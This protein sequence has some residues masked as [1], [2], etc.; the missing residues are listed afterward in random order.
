MVIVPFYLF[1]ALYAGFLFVCG[2]F[3]AIN[4]LHL[5]HTG[6]LTTIALLV[7][8]LIFGAV[9]LILLGTWQLLPDIGWSE[10]ITLFNFDSGNSLGF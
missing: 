8:A 2:I 10:P 6:T 3:F 9:A 5:V 1:L 4:L 7:S